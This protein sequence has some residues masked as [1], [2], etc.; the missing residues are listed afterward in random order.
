MGAKKTDDGTSIVWAI[1]LFLLFLV[2]AWPYFAGDLAGRATRGGQPVHSAVGDRLGPGS[3]VAGP[4]GVVR[5]VVV[6]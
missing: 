5:R 1:L 3:A 6:A 2:V 4:L